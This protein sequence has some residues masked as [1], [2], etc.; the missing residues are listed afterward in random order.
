MLKGNNSTKQLSR[1]N[2][3]QMLLTSLGNERGADGGGGVS[4]IKWYFQ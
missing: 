4:G 2:V 1:E 3:C